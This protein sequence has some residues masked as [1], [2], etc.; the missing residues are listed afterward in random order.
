MQFSSDVPEPVQWEC[1]RGTD[2]FMAVFNETFEK[3]KQQGLVLD[4]VTLDMKSSRPHSFYIP[5]QTEQYTASDFA[6]LNEAAQQVTL[7]LPDLDPNAGKPEPSE[8]SIRH[9]LAQMNPARQWG[10]DLF[11]VPQHQRRIYI[12]YV[13]CSHR[14][15]VTGRC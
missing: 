7:L 4:E 13:C 10:Y 15:S 2:Q 11:G 9:T 8:S 12:R 3:R 5:L 14:D 6:V 1:P